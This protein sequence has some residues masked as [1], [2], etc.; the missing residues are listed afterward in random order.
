MKYINTVHFVFIG[1]VLLF[2]SN[3]WA[4]NS[5]FDCTQNSNPGNPTQTYPSVDTYIEKDFPTGVLYSH[6][7]YRAG[8]EDTKFGPNDVL[9]HVFDNDRHWFTGGDYKLVV[10]ASQSGAECG[11]WSERKCS[12]EVTFLLR[13]ESEL[14]VAK[15]LCYAGNR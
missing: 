12:G 10:D 13:G 15:V 6:V 3:S 8:E 7:I 2:A 11:T 9:L 5:P 14:R 1:V 4:S